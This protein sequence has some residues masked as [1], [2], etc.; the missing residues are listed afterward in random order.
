MEEENFRKRTNV[1]FWVTL[2]TT[3]LVC[4]YYNQSPKLA[5]ILSIFAGFLT[6]GWLVM[7]EDILNPS[8]RDGHR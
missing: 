8:E 4:L 7:V 3:L 5:L 6:A 2:V 1:V